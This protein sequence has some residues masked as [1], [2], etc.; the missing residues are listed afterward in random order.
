MD[1][2][3]GE[4]GN[5][6]GKQENRK[7]RKDKFSALYNMKKKTYDLGENQWEK[8]ATFWKKK[9]VLLQ[10]RPVVTKTLLTFEQ[11]Y[12]WRTLRRYVTETNGIAGV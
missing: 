8:I 2:E 3:N 9:N 11:N 12:F 5:L 1:A 6:P 4:Q 10:N 7:K